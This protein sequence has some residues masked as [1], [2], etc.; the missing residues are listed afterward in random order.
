MESICKVT[1]ILSDSAASAA[2]VREAVEKS[3]TIQKP[4][5][6]QLKKGVYAFDEPLQL[7]ER[8]SGQPSRLK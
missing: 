6:I 5:T 8:D 7:D 4:C 2:L 1:P 3:R